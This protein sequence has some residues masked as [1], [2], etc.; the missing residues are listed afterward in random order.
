MHNTRKGLQRGGVWAALLLLIANVGVAQ[1]LSRASA[2]LFSGQPRLA[3]FALMRDQPEG[4]APTA[5]TLLVD[6]GVQP[7]GRSDPAR[8][9]LS[10]RFWPE[11]R[12]DDNVNAGIPGEYV[13]LGGL[14]FTVDSESRALAGV[15]AGFGA[16]VS[17]RFRLVPGRVLRVSGQM[18]ATHA[19]QHDISYWSAATEG[20][21]GQ[22][23]GNW[24]FVDICSGHSRSQRT[25]SDQS[26]VTWAALSG[27]THFE[28]RRGFHSLVI[29]ARQVWHSDDYRQVFASLSLNSAFEGVG[30][31]GL[32]LSAG[33]A[34]PGHQVVREQA[35]I[36]WSR[37]FAG[38][39][40]TLELGWQREDGSTVFGTA[41]EDRV[42]TLGVA[43]DLTRQWSVRVGWQNRRSSVPVYDEDRMTYNVTWRPAGA[44][45][46]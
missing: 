37:P 22:H 35:G 7:D 5:A 29:G 21:L 11:L 2:A 3:A 46:R 42:R 1:E 18:S 27:T 33:E 39:N 36:S 30:A 34:V 10:Y 23:V 31:L 20:C 16:S 25:G 43:V 13:Y 15:V 17:S 24:Q 12:W 38:R 32:S 4:L 8:L 40:V 26:R 19:P 6:E 44:T 45:I 41:R 9:S 28:S 14:K